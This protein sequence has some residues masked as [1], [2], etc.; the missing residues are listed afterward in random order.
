[1]WQCRLVP[2]EEWKRL[3]QR[4]RPIGAMAFASA[5]HAERIA[6]VLSPEYKRD[7]LGRRPP[8]LVMLPSRCPW[9]IDRLATDNA[10]RMLA[11]G[12]TVTGDPPAVTVH[13]SINLKGRWH[14]W[15]RDGVIT[16]DC[17]GRRYDA[18]GFLLQ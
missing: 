8:I 15:I 7:W 10:G 13:P 1:M 16:D 6:F 2:W 12:W 11:S 5:E 17:E 18:D 9:P 4:G 3:G 14:G